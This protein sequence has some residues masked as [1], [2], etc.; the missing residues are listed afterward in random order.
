MIL[1][2]L[3]PM[4]LLNAAPITCPPAFLPTRVSLVGKGWA[5]YNL[6]PQVLEKGAARGSLDKRAELN[7]E[8]GSN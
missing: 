3:F 6:I 8:L 2:I 5:L 7:A 4:Y 1:I